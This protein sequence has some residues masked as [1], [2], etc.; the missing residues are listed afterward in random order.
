MTAILQVHDVSKHFGGVEA[1][2]GVRF[3]VERGALVGLIGP[4]GAGKTTMVNI[5][6][7]HQTSTSGQILLDGKPIQKYQTFEVAREGV[8]RTYQ[9]NRLFLEDTVSENIRIGLVWSGRAHRPDLTYPGAQG[10]ENQRLEAL[11]ALFCLKPYSDIMPNE[12]G[13]LVRRRVEIAQALAL[14]PKLLL[15]DEPFAG[16]SREEA[17]EL[18][19]ILRECQRGGLTILLIEH[20][21]EVVMNICEYL[22]VMHHGA[23]L[24]SG[25]PADIQTN[26]Q[27]VS[28]YLG[29]SL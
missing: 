18:I 29:A 28:V 11:L 27:V 4:N 20:N 9:Q 13:H 25:K 7:A 23:L 5:I 26:E 10:S 8:S 3:D 1:V 21:M 24:A 6:S 17:D 16:F 15:L 2:K 14:A 12:L 19:A 22:Y